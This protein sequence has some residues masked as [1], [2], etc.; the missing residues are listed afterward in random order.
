LTNGRRQLDVATAEE[1]PNVTHSSTDPTIVSL[2]EFRENVQ[3]GALAQIESYWESLRKGRIMPSRS[4]IDPRGI[5]SVLEH[6]FILERVARG[7]GRFRLAGIHLNDVMGMEVRGMPLTA[8]IL[9]ESR[10]EMSAALSAVFDEP[11]IVRLTLGSDT[12][13]GRSP[14]DARML[15]LPLRSDLGDVSRVLGGF[16]TNG[17]IGR[18]PR[19]FGITAQSRRTLIGYGDTV[20]TTS[21]NGTEAQSAPGKTRPSGRPNLVLVAPEE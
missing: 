2:A 19:R 1:R 16:V 11:A 17:K 14:M 9:P 7:V 8:L 4:E 20:S 5:T 13:L 6:A 12:G 15:L 10:D 3:H 21:H 18:A